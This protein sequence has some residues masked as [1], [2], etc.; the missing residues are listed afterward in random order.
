MKSSDFRH[1][2]TAAALALALAQAGSTPLRAQSRAVWE[3]QTNGLITVHVENTQE[4]PLGYLLVNETDTSVKGSTS[5]ILAA[6]SQ[7][8]PGSVS[9]LDIPKKK[10]VWVTICNADAP[11]DDYTIRQSLNL[12]QDPAPKK[13]PFYFLCAPENATITTTP[14]KGATTTETL[15]LKGG[16]RSLNGDTGPIKEYKKVMMFDSTDE[17]SFVLKTIGFGLRAMP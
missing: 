8:I 9:K 4:A 3:N 14:G 6:A 10:K 12:T 16:F 5:R 1:F 17:S 7:N 2:F 13:I 15:K 11:H